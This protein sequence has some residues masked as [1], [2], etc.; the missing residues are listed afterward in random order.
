L[1]VQEDQ[2]QWVQEEVKA[3]L[4]QKAHK[5]QMVVVEIKVHKE[6]QVLQA[7]LAL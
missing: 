6:Q 5:E 2:V 3:Q 1:V 7:L 4:E